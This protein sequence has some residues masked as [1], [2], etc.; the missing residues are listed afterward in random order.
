MHIIKFQFFLAIASLG[1]I[2]RNDSGEGGGWGQAWSPW[3]PWDSLLDDGVD[4]LDRLWGKAKGFASRKKAFLPNG[5]YSSSEGGK[6]EVELLEGS[7]HSLNGFR[8]ATPNRNIGI[9]DDI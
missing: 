6:G 9:F 2:V 3:R 5:R 8:S 4:H 1:K 7:T